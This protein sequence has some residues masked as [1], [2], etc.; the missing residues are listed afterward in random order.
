MSENCSDEENIPDDVSRELGRQSMYVTSIKTKINGFKTKDKSLSSPSPTPMSASD[1]RLKLP[2]L[3]C[4]TFSGEGVSQ[5]EFHSFI[6][7]FNNVIGFR[8]NITD[9]IKLTYLKTYLKGYAHKLVNHLQVSN[10]NYSVALEL[11]KSEFLNVN[12]LVDDLIAKFMKLKPEYDTAFLKTKEYL[13]DIRSIVSDLKLYDYDFLNERAGNRLLSH[14]V[15]SRLP[16][17]FQQ[18]I[19]RKLNDNYPT[20]HQIL[21]NYV[22]VIRTLNLRTIKP[23]ADSVKPKVFATVSRTNF[24]TPNK[25]SSGSNARVS[26]RLCKFCAS[27]SHSMVNCHRYESANARRRRCE[28]MKL[29]KLCSSS[30]HAAPDCRKPLDYPCNYC[31]SHSHISYRSWQI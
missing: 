23:Q 21:D 19:V 18:E 26:A 24:I 22:E 15:F 8:T 31:Q 3:K 11:L 1:C 6:T 7:S 17:P 12:T 13:G 30:R 2:E 9:S 10:E 16:V 20:L 5:L 14:I 27:T 4:E 28:E 25:N 29:C